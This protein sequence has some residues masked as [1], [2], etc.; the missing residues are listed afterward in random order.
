[1]TQPLKQSKGMFAP[2]MNNYGDTP[3]EQLE[4]NQPLMEKLRKWIE[5]TEAEEITVEEENERR[6]YWEEFKQNIDSFR[7]E[8]HKLYSEE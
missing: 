1:M 5:E 7:P 6:T 2:Y 4:K 8:G 3:E